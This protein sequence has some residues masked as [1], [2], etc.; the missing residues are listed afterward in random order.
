MLGKREQHPTTKVCQAFPFSSV[1]CHLGGL[2]SSSSPSSRGPRLCS[3]QGRWRPTHQS[4]A[5]TSWTTGLTVRLVD[6][7]A[8]SWSAKTIDQ[9]GCY[10]RGHRAQPVAEHQARP[11]SFAAAASRSCPLSVGLKAAVKAQ[12]DV[13]HLSSVSGSLL[14]TSLALPGSWPTY[15]AARPKALPDPHSS[16]RGR[17][18]NELRPG[19][20]SRLRLRPPRAPSIRIAEA[21]QHRDVKA[22]EQDFEQGRVREKT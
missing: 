2:P 17:L 22:E 19:P 15:K 5:N 1:R 16:E 20:Q 13:S 8:E 21:A 9:P 18:S 14:C 11:G 12:E 4:A 6:C 3:S 7:S 10:A